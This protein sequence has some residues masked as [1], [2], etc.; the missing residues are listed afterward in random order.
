MCKYNLKQRT[1]LSVSY[2][3]ACLLSQRP[4]SLFARQCRTQRRTGRRC[5]SRTRILVF[6][7]ASI[8]RDRVVSA[9]VCFGPIGLDLSKSKQEFLGEPMRK[10]RGVDTGNGSF[11]CS[12][13]RFC[14]FSRYHAALRSLLVP[15]RQERASG[16]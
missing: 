4:F 9:S 10:R 1:K 6:L 5:C 11:R 15:G 3:A 7:Y 16:D 14:S 2:T 12:R 13:G 8:A